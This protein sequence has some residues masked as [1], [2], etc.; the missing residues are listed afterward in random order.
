MANEA[1]SESFP[2]I[3]MPYSEIF[4]PL[5]ESPV[6][7]QALENYMVGTSRINFKRG[8]GITR[9]KISY[10]LRAV[11]LSVV[12]SVL[13]P[14]PFQ[15]EE[16]KVIVETSI[17]VALARCCGHILPLAISVFLL[18]YNFTG[19]Y[20]GAQLS[21]PAYISD[22]VKFQ[23]LQ[24]VAKAHELLI[25]GSTA[26][27]IFHMLRNQLLWG[28]GIPLGLVASGFSFTELSFFW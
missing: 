21:G 27:V 11:G 6:R 28:S 14:G 3:H 15:V 4:R 5:A 18:S 20:I 16:K 8:W 9:R 19:S 2:L 10:L 22:S 1:S 7:P 25:L 13:E 23:L 24:F 17:W 12:S 26:N